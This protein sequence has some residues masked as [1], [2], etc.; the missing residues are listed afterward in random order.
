MKLPNAFSPE[1]LAELARPVARFDPRDAELVPGLTPRWHVIET[2]AHCEREVAKELIARRF[3]IFV[4]EGTET[5]VRRGRRIDRIYL[6]FPGYIFVF[7]WLSDLNFHR[8]TC[9]PGVLQLLS[10]VEGTPLIL[11]DEQ[12]DE[13]RAV[14][15]AERAELP[16]SKSKRK[17]RRYS[18]RA[19]DDDVIAVR[20][21]SAFQDR[22]LTLDSEG[23]NQTLRKALG[24]S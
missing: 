2:Y 23:R 7:L 14:E 18:N 10:S 11:S 21:W 15:N 22:L 12:I 3:G 17:K 6:M 19:Y 8:V 16:S 20:P 24:L 13:I 1:V 4:P 5:I 9:T